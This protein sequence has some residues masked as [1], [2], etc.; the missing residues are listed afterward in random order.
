MRRSII[1]TSSVA[2][3]LLLAACGGDDDGGGTTTDSGAVIDSTPA[4]DSVT[5]DTA[6]TDTATGDTATSD[7]ATADSPATDS[8]TSDTPADSPSDGATACTP[9]ADIR[10][11]FNAFAGGTV[12]ATANVTPSVCS[13]GAITLGTTRKTIAV[14][15]GA[16]VFFLGDAGDTL[17]P[18][19]SM[20]W[21]RPAGS[22]GDEAIDVAAKTNVPLADYDA[23]KAHVIVQ[24]SAPAGATTCDA[25]GF[26]VTVP[27]HA[28]AKVQYTTSGSFTIDTALTA[29][30]GTRGGIAIIQKIDPGSPVTISATKTGCDANF[31]LTALFT[32]RAPLVAGK[33]VRAVASVTVK[34]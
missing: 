10:L 17:W 4:G 7:T 16:N 29:T 31:K 6:T 2:V 33:V 11:I 1:R 20:E 14:P 28:E 22:S 21:N 26:V 12:P 19:A 5:T 15:V 30:S 13:T 27:G 18:A 24:L 23:T 34:P 25:S 3:G 9:T 8:A 32:G